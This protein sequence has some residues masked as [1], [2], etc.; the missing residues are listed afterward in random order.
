M[1]RLEANSVSTAARVAAG[2]LHPAGAFSS[3]KSPMS[4]PEV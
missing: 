3:G 4:T 2:P 1:P